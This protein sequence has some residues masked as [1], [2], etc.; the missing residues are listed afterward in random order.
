VLASL[1]PSSQTV[2]SNIR[3]IHEQGK[4]STRTTEVNVAPLRSL[5]TRWP[6]SLHTYV[7]CA[8]V[9]SRK[10]HSTAKVRL[11]TQPLKIVFNI[12]F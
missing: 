2:G 11:K 8:N 4:R 9:A 10:C 7:I 6:L 5:A 1:A 3:V 12:F